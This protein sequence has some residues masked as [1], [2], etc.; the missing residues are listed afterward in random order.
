MLKCVSSFLPYLKVVLFSWSNVLL[1]W[2]YVQHLHK[3]V[4][5]DQATLNNV[6]CHIT[7]LT[8]NNKSVNQTCVTKLIFS[9]KLKLISIRKKNI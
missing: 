5:N 8:V 3:E 1:N 9:W 2:D 4:L 7:A 6:M